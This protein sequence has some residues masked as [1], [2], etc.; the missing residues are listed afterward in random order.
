MRNDMDAIE[1]IVYFL[2]LTPVLPW[3]FPILY[4]IFVSH[5]LSDFFVNLER[6]DNVSVHLEAEWCLDIMLFF[7]KIRR[8]LDDKVL[9]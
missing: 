9:F 1:A 7:C 3:I 6:G 5:D 8:A 2:V 4:M